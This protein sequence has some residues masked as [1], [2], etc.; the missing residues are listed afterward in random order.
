MGRVDCG[1]CVSPSFGCEAGHCVR[2]RPA[3]RQPDLVADRQT[4][5][6]LAERWTEYVMTMQ[7]LGVD[8]DRCADVLRRLEGER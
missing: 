3:P 7:I 4:A 5:V 6:F 2:A 8:Q 1:D